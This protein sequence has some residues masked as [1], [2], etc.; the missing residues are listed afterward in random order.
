MYMK[1][2]TANDTGILEIN[3]CKIF[4]FLDL[5]DINKTYEK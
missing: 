3:Y 1:K 2:M 4:G 5:K